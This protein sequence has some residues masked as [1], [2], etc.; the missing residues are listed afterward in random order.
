MRNIFNTNLMSSI[1]LSNFALLIFILNIPGTIGLRNLLAGILLITLLFEILRDDSL[2][3][4]V[5]FDKQ[6]KHILVILSI[7]TF[8]IFFHTVF[9]AD[10]FEWSF[11]QYRTQWIYPMLYFLMG[12]LLSLI[13]YKNKYFTKEALLTTML[14]SLFAHIVYIDLVAIY[15]FLENGNLLYRYGGLTQSS[16][17][18]NYVTNIVIA[19]VFVEFI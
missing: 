7:L 3:G 14:L 11:S 12:I 15:K 9:I 18:A 5:Y 6:L 10:D 4:L 17:L 1:I 2:K 16:V 13:T 8:Y 19:I